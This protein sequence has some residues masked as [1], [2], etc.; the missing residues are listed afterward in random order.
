LSGI[1]GGGF[2]GAGRSL[3][4]QSPFPKGITPGRSFGRLNASRSLGQTID[5]RGDVRVQGQ[6]L[7]L[8]LQRAETTRSRIIG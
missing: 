7:I 5:V 3:G 6:D 4:V 2:G 1:G 8:A